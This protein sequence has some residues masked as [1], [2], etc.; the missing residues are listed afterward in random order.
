MNQCQTMQMLLKFYSNYGFS[1]DHILTR[2]SSGEEHHSWILY[3][4][5]IPG[6]KK[7]QIIGSLVDG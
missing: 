4:L 1:L 5:L 6:K 3:N 2:E 7:K